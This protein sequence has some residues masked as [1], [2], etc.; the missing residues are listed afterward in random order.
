MYTTYH[1]IYLQKHIVPT[2]T[3]TH[4]NLCLLATPRQEAFQELEAD[5]L[6][7]CPGSWEEA[8]QEKTVLG[9]REVQRGFPPVGWSKIQ[10][11][12]HI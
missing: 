9:R 11:E 12:N 4:P 6:G 10:G 3:H 7:E 8:T 2:Q 5:G 1:I